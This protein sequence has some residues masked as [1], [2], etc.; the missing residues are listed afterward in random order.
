ML[1]NTP[2]NPVRFAN[3]I[4]IVIERNRRPE[5]IGKYIYIFYFYTT[6]G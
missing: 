2:H 5:E 3:T 6:S 1:A 4:G